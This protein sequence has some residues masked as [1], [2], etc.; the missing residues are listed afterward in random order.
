MA[1]TT[2]LALSSV[3]FVSVF[4]HSSADYFRSRRC[5]TIP[6]ALSVITNTLPYLAIQ[7]LAPYNTALYICIHSVP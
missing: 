6:S 4:C 7:R 2:L 3:T 1:A 5:R